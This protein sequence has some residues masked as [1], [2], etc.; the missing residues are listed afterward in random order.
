MHLLLY[1]WIHSSI[2]WLS[3]S[4][5]GVTGDQIVSWPLTCFQPCSELEH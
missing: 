1:I 4:D 5:I 2:L 3:P